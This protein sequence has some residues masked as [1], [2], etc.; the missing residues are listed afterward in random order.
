MNLTGTTQS[1][2]LVT[3]TAQ[4]IDYVLEYTIIDKTGATTVTTPASSQGNIVAATTTTILAAPAASV[5]YIIRNLFIRNKGAA[6][7]NITLQKDVAG[8]NRLVY[9]CSL[10][11][12]ETVVV[13]EDSNI[14]VLNSSGVP[15]NATIVSPNA[16]VLMAPHFATSSL[17]GVKTITSLSSFAIYVGKAPRALTSVA[18]RARVTTAMA[19]ITW[20]EVAIAK[21]PVVI[22]GNPT[23]TVVG[24]A[25]VSATYDSTGQKSTT[26]NVTA[27][28][29]IDEGDDLWV[30]IG[31]SAT[32]AAVMRA[33]TIADDLQVGLQASVV[34]RPSLL[35]GTPTAFTI[36]GATVLGA[37][38]A[39][40]C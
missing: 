2:E 3:S 32:T 29:S 39:V 38:V 26:I 8:T 28:Q 14:M 18:L 34:G 24:W 19:T 12:N 27:G 37:W 17:A 23:L 30:I 15:K 4:S 36:E 35:V 22:G 7:N 33:Q 1:L 10:G 40:V 25:D 6:V 5:Y 31:N 13:D 20:G 9:A 21:G 11:I 16:S